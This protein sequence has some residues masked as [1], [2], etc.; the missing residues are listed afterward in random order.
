MSNILGWQD[1]ISVPITLLFIYTLANWKYQKY[2]QTSL[3]KYFFLG[4]HLKML[5]CVAHFAYHYYI[6]GGGDTFNYYRVSLNW[7]SAFHQL[8]WETLLSLLQSPEQYDFKLLEALPDAFYQ[9]P[10]ERRLTKITGLIGLL[11]FGS[12]ISIG[13]WLSFFA[14]WGTWRIFKVFATIKP[15]LVQYAAIST[16]FIPSI[17][18]W[19]GSISKDAVTMGCLGLCFHAIYTLFF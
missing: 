10:N 4:L 15:H 12:F 9:S 18:F 1:V 16:L 5:A 2:K 14:Y 6:Y 13:L 3:G 11:T 19:S 8:P 17:I 7:V